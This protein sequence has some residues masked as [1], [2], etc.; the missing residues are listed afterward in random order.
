LLQRLESIRSNHPFL[1]TSIQ[2]QWVQP[3]IA[4]RVSC[5]KQDLQTG[6]LIG[7]SWKELLGAVR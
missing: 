1:A 4:C 7:A 5:E 6:R 3:Q 2:A